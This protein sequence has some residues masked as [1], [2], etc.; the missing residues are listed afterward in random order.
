M[1]NLFE[2]LTGEEYKAKVVAEYKQLQSDYE[3]LNMF[4]LKWKTGLL[5]FEPKC[6]MSIYE[7]KVKSMEKELDLLKVIATIENID[8][9]ITF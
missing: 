3:E 5:G 6:P 7:A 8:V 9:T 4:L 2:N 1:K